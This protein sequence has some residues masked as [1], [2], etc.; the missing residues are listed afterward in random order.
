MGV[1]RGGAEVDAGVTPAVACG[2]AEAVES[3]A[4]GSSVETTVTVAAAAPVK[5]IEGAI[6]SKYI[7]PN[8]KC[9]GRTY[10]P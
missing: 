8:W 4:V 6:S 1:A 9:V 5:V 2:S 7:H 10:I 3:S